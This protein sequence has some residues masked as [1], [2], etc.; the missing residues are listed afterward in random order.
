MDKYAAVIERNA[1]AAGNYL[2]DL[3]KALGLWV[4]LELSPVEKNGKV[5]YL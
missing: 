2:H 5:R 4:A 1:I 3:G